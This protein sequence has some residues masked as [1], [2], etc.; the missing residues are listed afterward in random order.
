MATSAQ[1]GAWLLGG[2]GVPAAAL[3]AASKTLRLPDTRVTTLARTGG[4]DGMVA[5]GRQPS[6]DL[7]NQPEIT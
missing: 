2:Y 3:L 1:P 4:G 5:A 6:Q 7:D